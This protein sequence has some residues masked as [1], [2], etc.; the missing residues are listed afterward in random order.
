MYD[1]DSISPVLVFYMRAFIGIEVSKEVRKSARPLIEALAAE[2]VKP[3]SPDNLHL[4]LFFLGEIDD[5]RADRVKEAMDEVKSTAFDIRF[6]GV[7]AFPNQNFI[8]VVWIGCSAP[9][10]AELHGELAP[11]IAKMGYPGEEFRPHLT[12]ARVGD[13]KAKETVKEAL[14]AFNGRKFGI[15]KADRITLYSSKLTPRGPVYEEVYTKRLP[16]KE[17]KPR[18][19]RAKKQA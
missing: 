14:L 19:P 12:V 6:E 18:K 16:E 5:V 11:A 3:V 13:P 2:G 15:S 1:Y 10:L 4:T 8:R 17:K 7:G 9:G